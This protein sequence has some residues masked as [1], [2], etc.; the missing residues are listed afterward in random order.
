MKEVECN[1]SLN[2]NQVCAIFRSR[3]IRPKRFVWR[4]H[5]TPYWCSFEG[6][7]YGRRKPTEI[8]V[9]EFFYKCV[10]SSLEDL[11]RIKGEGKSEKELVRYLGELYAS[12]KGNKQNM[13]N[14]TI[15]VK[16]ITKMHDSKGRTVAFTL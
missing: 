4:P 3:D 10:K 13:Y 2:K 16:S 15:S 12:L 8:S 1:K 5:Q 9:F 7:K 14:L 11:I 6:H